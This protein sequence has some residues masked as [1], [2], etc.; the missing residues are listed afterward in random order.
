MARDVT[1]LKIW[2]WA[3]GRRQARH[4]VMQA[5]VRRAGDLSVLRLATNTATPPLPRR[6]PLTVP[7][8]L[9]P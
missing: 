8:T 5:G 1:T 7:S 2:N 3:M 4:L 9:A 6:T